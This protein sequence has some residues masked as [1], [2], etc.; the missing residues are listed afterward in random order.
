MDERGGFS[1]L[2]FIALT[3]GIFA[4]LGFFMVA[5]AVVATAGG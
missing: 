1:A 2:F 5:G 4:L 3:L